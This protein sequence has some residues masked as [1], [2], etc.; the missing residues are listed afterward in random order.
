MT[1]SFFLRRD[2]TAV[3]VGDMVGGTEIHDRVQRVPEF[4]LRTPPTL[5]R[6]IQSATACSLNMILRAP[7]RT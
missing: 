7:T 2:A 5:R 3:A 6:A 4:H 1:R